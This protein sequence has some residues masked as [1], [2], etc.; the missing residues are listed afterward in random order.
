MEKAE[1]SLLFGAY[2]KK[3]RLENKMTQP[4][5]ADK[6]GNNFQNISAI[7]RGEF[8]ITIHTAKK[9]ADAFQISLSAL[10]KGFE[11]YSFKKEE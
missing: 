3:L 7:E 2:I 1:F 9:F 5:L 11:D 10:F 8:T 4:E 6:L